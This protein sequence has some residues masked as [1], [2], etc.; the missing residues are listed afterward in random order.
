MKTAEGNSEEKSGTYIEFL[1]DTEIFGK[2]KYSE[3][4]LKRRFFHYACLNKG[5]K[6]IIMIKFLSL[7]KG[8]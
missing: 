4:F 3:D 5:L 7:R 2:Y 1:A 8:L 6:L